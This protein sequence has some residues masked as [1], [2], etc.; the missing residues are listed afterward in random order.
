MIGN[1]YT[2]Q[3]FY[4]PPR[5]MGGLERWV[6]YGCKPGGFLTAVLENDLRTAC[7]LADSENLTNIPAYI[8]YLYNNTPADCWGSKDKVAAWWKKFDDERTAKA[9]NEEFMTIGLPGG[10][11]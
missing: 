2:Y 3:T 1:K 5:M 10:H 9:A 7:E 11:D 6:L 4:I 8:A